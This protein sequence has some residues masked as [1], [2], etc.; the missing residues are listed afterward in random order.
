MAFARR[1][2]LLILML[3]VVIAAPVA[4]QTKPDLAD[5]LEAAIEKDGPTIAQQRFIEI[6][7]SGGAEKYTLDQRKLGQLLQSYVQAGEV[8]EMQAVANVMAEYSVAMS[9]ANG[10]VIPEPQASDRTERASATDRSVTTEESVAMRRRERL[11][12][13]RPD[14]DRF[15]GFYGVAPDGQ[16]GMRM[17]FV[18]RSCDG[19]LTVGPMWADTQEWYLRSTGDT[20]FEYPGDSFNPV[21]HIAFTAPARGRATGMKLDYEG[22]T[23][24]MVRLRD[25]D[26]E[27]IPNCEGR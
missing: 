22:F 1:G 9:R 16:N 6:L 19:Y 5:A 7:R 14:N 20:S 13:P 24:P 27:W 21:V 23:D 8:D 25:L 15:M 18:S 26:P 4:G 2:S 10:M 17:W 11:G 12:E 3:A